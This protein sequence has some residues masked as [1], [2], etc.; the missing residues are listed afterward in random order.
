MSVCESLKQWSLRATP[1]RSH[2]RTRLILP[3]CWTYYRMLLQRNG[4]QRR[5]GFNI[6][7]SR[8][9]GA[10]WLQLKI[11]RLLKADR[12]GAAVVGDDARLSIGTARSR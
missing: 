2:D 5:N 8:F 12:R 9:K 6:G 4:D 11:A 1:K 7:S 3:I 10:H